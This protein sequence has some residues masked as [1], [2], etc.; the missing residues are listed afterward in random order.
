MMEE[1]RLFAHAGL[2]GKGGGD[3]SDISRNS[4]AA[5]DQHP[6]EHS[7]A[8]GSRRE[9]E[10]VDMATDA[11][12]KSTMSNLPTW[13]MRATLLTSVSSGRDLLSLCP[14]CS[15]AEERD[16]HQF[17][18][19]LPTAAIWKFVCWKFR[20]RWSPTT[21]L[22]GAFMDGCVGPAAVRVLADTETMFPSHHLVHEGRTCRN[23]LS[24]VVGRCG[25]TTFRSYMQIIRRERRLLHG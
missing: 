23:N 25:S 4:T 22:M 21:D 18:S 6:I 17:F 24:L 1:D 20:N 3:F 7:K 10:E 16:R 9:L 15:N 11:Q 8:T 13:A 5:F 14:L 2:D 12:Q 19:Y